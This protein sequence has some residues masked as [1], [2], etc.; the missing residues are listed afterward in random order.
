[1]VT[2]LRK[3]VIKMP[4]VRNINTRPQYASPVFQAAASNTGLRVAAHARVS[5]DAEE[6]SSSFEAQKDYY[7]RLINETPGWT[8]AGIYADRGITGTSTEHRA[9]LRWEYLHMARRVDEAIERISD[10]EADNLDLKD[11]LAGKEVV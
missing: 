2:T 8:F 3:L 9:G 11:A 7:E 1:M 5:T 6:Q 4:N 10:L